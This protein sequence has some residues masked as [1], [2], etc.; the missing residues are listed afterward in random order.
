MNEV[1]GNPTSSSFFPGIL[2]EYP[3]LK[4]FW[5]RLTNT[6][7]NLIQPLI[8]NYYS[9]PQTDDM[10]KYLRPDMPDVREI[11]KDMALLFVNSHFSFH[12]IRPVTPGFVEIGGL[13]VEMD[14][15]QLTPVRCNK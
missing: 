13:H 14:R 5:Q 7:E 15:S 9:R 12:G 3:V 6:I 10:R 4:N 2:V 11:E 8:F 1:M